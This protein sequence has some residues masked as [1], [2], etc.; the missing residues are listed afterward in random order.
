MVWHKDE[1]KNYK[2]FSLYSTANIACKLA[3]LAA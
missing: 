2:I 3:K 1:L